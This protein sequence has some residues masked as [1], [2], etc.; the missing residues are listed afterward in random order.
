MIY[1]KGYLNFLLFA[2]VVMSKA[3]K[4]LCPLKRAAEKPAKGDSS[5]V[6]SQKRK[7]CLDSTTKYGIH[8]AHYMRYDTHKVVP[9]LSVLS[10]SGEHATSFYLNK[11]EEFHEREKMGGLW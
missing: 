3:K 2:L 7:P 10:L 8:I 9:L 11:H 1:G 6:I 4:V 5:R